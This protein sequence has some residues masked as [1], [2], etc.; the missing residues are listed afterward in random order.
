LES[1]DDLLADLDVIIRQVITRAPCARNWFS[2]PDER[3]LAEAATTA[4]IPY[5]KPTIFDKG[6]EKFSEALVTHISE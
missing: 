4:P 2:S 3:S 6:V 5:V 1:L